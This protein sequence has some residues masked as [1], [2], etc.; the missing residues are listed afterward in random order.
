MRLFKQNA[1]CACSSW[2]RLQCEYCSSEQGRSRRVQCVHSF[3]TRT[4]YEIITFCHF[5][6]KHL[7]LTE[8]NI[9]PK[10]VTI[11]RPSPTVMVVS[12]IPLSYSEARGFISHYTVAYSPLTSGQALDTMTQTVPG[13][14]TNTTRIEGL[15]ANTDYIVQVSA[16][17][18]AGTSHLSAPLHVVTDTTGMASICVV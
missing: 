17:N 1:C 6:V 10:N 14:D 9:P 12:W 7:D 5:I 8:P 11:T 15:D 16:T 18:G 3:Y 13:M 2:S 4:R